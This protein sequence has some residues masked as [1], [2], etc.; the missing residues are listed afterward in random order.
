MTCHE[1]VVA[2]DLLV[3]SDCSGSERR[4]WGFKS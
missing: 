4:A 2:R 3:L 1:A